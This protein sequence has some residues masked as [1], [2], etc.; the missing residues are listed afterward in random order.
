MLKDSEIVGTARR[1]AV[2]L[3][4]GMTLASML[5]FGVLAEPAAGEKST[6]SPKV[7]ELLTSLARE[8]L[9]AQGVAKAAAPPPQQ[10]GNSFEDYVNSDADAIHDQI[11]ALA[12]A[13]P[14]LP[15]E[16]ERAAARV[17]AIDPD[18]GRGQVFLDLGIFGD[19][20]MAATRRLAAEAHTF[21]NLVILGA[22]GFGA[23]WL[24][25][26]MTGRARRRLDVLPMV[27]VKDRLHVIAARFAFDFGNLRSAARQPMAPSAA[28]KR[29]HVGTSIGCWRT[30]FT[31]VR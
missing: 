11:V 10:I 6:A 22:C 8:W 2:V 20:Y 19:P 29:S 5:S 4:G 21:L 15:H 13:I 18:A 1:A 14:G 31:L 16:F 17:T 30:R 12:G 3:L 24:F 25:R 27:T 23:Q 9:D 7:D 28:A 26:K